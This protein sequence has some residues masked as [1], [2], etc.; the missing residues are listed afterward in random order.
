[1]KDHAPS[2][3]R[4]RDDILAALLG[5]LPVRGTIL[6]IASGTGQHAVHF[7]REFAEAIWQPSERRPEALA[8]IRAWAA[9]ADLPI[10]AEP[11]ELD[12]CWSDWPVARADAIVNFNMLHITPM[13]LVEGDAVCRLSEVPGSLDAGS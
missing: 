7:A 5:V 10:L 4:N 1:M 11:I 9:E 6:E 2:V 13:Q 8:S 3:E 12:V